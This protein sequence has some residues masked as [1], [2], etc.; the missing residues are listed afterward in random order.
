[1]S[2]NLSALPMPNIDTSTLP[3]MSDVGD[4]V[5]D[6]LVTAIDTAGEAATVVVE[7]ARRSPKAAIGVVSAAVVALLVVM[8]MRRRRRPPTIDARYEPSPR[9]VAA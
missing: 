6:V 2:L 4:V 8:L 3:S 9:I 5:G 1:M 7:T